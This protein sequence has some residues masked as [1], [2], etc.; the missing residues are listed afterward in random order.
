VSVFE[1]I[2]VMTTKANVIRVANVLF[3]AN[4]NGSVNILQSE[5]AEKLGTNKQEVSRAI[6]TL[7]SMG[8]ID[9]QKNGTSYTYHINNR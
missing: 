8:M 1:K 3:S 5:I 6:K 9:A 7:I 2:A 4:Q